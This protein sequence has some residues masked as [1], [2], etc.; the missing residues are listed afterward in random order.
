[1]IYSIEGHTDMTAIKQKNI[2]PR[3]KKK[4]NINSPRLIV[5]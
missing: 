1:M 4:L 3:R 5:I 2:G